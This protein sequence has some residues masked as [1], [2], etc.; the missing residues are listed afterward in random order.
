MLLS[1]CGTFETLPPNAPPAARLIAHRGESAVAPENTLES[2]RLA[3]RNGAAWG[4]ET[5]VHLT[6]DGVL[7]CCHD[8]N[9][10]RTAGV[11]G[12]IADLTVR[13]LKQLD[14]GSWKS[15]EYCNSRIPTLREFLLETPSRGHLFVEIKKSGD[16]F[17]EAFH[18]AIEG[19]GVTPDQLT[20]ISFNPVELKRAQQACPGIR[21]LL[22]KSIS[23]KSGAQVPEIEE[24]IEELRCNGF[25]GADLGT[26][27]D[28]LQVFTAEYIRKLHDAGFEAHFWTVDDTETAKALLSRG[29]DSITTNRPAAMSK[30]W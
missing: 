15:A 22:L 29:A 10:A 5:D 21:T 16:D 28:F 7:V 18:R 26:D 13:E 24:L 25:T 4:V 27:G 17:A 12:K 6:K 9:T 20:I 1:N 30:E 2:C 19:S 23:T 8:E 11:P 3:W 14:V